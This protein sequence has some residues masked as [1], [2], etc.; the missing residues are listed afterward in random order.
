[1]VSLMV[2]GYADIYKDNTPNHL[3]TDT[4]SNRRSI[5]T[6]G[7]KLF[8][9]S[10]LSTEPALPTV[11]VKPK[12]TGHSKLRAITVNVIVFCVD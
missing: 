12:I 3:R 10:T 6:K 11:A 9:I 4:V 7:F 8:R 1:M 2:N 5:I